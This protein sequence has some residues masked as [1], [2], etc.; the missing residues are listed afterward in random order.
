MRSRGSL[1]SRKLK[2]SG[3]SPTKSITGSTTH[4]RRRRPRAFPNSAVV[5]NSF[6]KYFCMTGWRIGWMVV[7]ETLVRTIERL[8]QNLAISVPTLVADCGARPRSTDGKRWSGSSTATKKT[9]VFSAR[10]CRRRDSTNFCRWTAHF[11]SMPNL[12]IFKRQSR[13]R[14]THVE[15]GGRCRDAGDRF[16]SG[17]WPAFSALLLRRLCRRDA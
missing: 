1:R 4:L 17:Q 9:V 8:Q 5:I 2:A 16:R 10:D 7:P 14:Q 11:I 6:S 12:A 15:R 13:L 3:S